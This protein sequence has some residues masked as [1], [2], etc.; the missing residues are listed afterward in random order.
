V[1]AGEY[2]IGL[3][4]SPRGQVVLR[5]LNAKVE[6]GKTVSDKIDL[7][8][9]ATVEGRVAA[10]IDYRGTPLYVIPDGADA[11]MIKP[12]CAARHFAIL[13]HGAFKIGPLP[14]GKYH[15]SAVGGCADVV[16]ADGKAVTGV[17]IRPAEKL[18]KFSGKIKDYSYGKYWCE[19]VYLVGNVV[20]HIPVRPDG[21]FNGNV[22]PGKYKMFHVDY[23]PRYIVHQMET[24]YFTERIIHGPSDITIEDGKDLADVEIP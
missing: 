10:K 2:C 1:P 5:K 24:E 6:P 15:I 16:V 4:Y 9:S 11:S 19:Y 3:Y 17:Q 14:P 21:T 22:P 13:G 18:Q 8:G 20:T 7:T 23:A 12:F